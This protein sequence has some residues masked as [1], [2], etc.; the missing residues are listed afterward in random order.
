M[1]TSPRFLHA[2]LIV[3]DEWASIGSSNL[4]RWGL[5]WNLEANQE[6]ESPEFAAQAAA[7]FLQAY[8]QVRFCGARATSSI[9]GACRFGA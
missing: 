2:K 1:S 9:I 4:D 8:D 5:L 3:C 6:I 7:M